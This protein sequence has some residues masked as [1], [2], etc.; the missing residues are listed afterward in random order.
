MFSVNE[1]KRP[2]NIH[3][4][5]NLGHTLTTGTDLI[6]F[7]ILSTYFYLYQHFKMPCIYGALLIFL[8]ETYS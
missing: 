7:G 2:K 1:L 8:S 3:P 4:N 6:D 5:N